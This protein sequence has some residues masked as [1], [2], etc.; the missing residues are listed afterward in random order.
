MERSEKDRK[1][2]A[3]L[4]SGAVLT[5]LYL[6][7][8][9]ILG[10]APEMKPWRCL[11][12]VPINAC[13]LAIAWVYGFKSD[14]RIF[15][16]LIFYAL[17]DIIAPAN[18]LAGGAFFGI[19]HIFAIDRYIRKYGMSKRQL[20][21]FAGISAFLITTLVLTLGFDWRVPLIA[22]YIMILAALPVSS[23]GNRYFFITVCIFLFSD[24]IAYVRK[25]FF[26]VNWLYDI[27]L[28][29]YYAAIVMYSFSFRKK[30]G[31]CGT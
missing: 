2:L 12:K 23:F 7:I 24:V 9:H 1:A 6:A 17:G 28:P 20:L 4:I 14:K 27:T 8:C 10:R 3:L 13:W 25:M 11:V 31:S 26:N 21:C 22:V 18:Y 16:A 5:V 30:E 19:G 29:V 15:L